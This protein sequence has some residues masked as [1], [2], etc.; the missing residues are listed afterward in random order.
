RGRRFAWEEDWSDAIV[1]PTSFAVRGSPHDARRVVRGLE[2]TL[3]ATRRTVHATRSRRGHAA[4][5]SKTFTRLLFR[6]PSGCVQKAALRLCLQKRLRISTDT[7]ARRLSA[8][9]LR[10]LFFRG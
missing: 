5:R 7:H 8:Q 10:A 2:G 6:K 3:N 4:P 1:Y 9:S